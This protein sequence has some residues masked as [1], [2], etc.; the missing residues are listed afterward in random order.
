M[1]IGFLSG[2]YELLVEKKPASDFFQFGK[3]KVLKLWVIRINDIVP[4][5]FLFCVLY[6]GGSGGFK[7][8]GFSGRG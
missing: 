2:L 5:Y 7:G 4:V 8:V 3:P 6:E 1:R